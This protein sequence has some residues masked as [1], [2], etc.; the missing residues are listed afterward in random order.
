MQDSP[1]AEWRV[2]VDCDADFPVHEGEIV[3]FSQRDLKTPRRCKDCR[4]ARRLLRDVE[5]PRNAY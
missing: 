5:T 3:Y 1:I 2:C 4:L